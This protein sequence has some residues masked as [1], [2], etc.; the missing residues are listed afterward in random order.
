MHIIYL[1]N[2]KSATKIDNFARGSQGGNGNT[3][4]GPQMAFGAPPMSGPPQWSNVPGSLQRP[5]ELIVL[6]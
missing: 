5:L 1:T 2:L 3:W 4:G 6:S